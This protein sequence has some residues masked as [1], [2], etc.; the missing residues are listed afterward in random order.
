MRVLSNMCSP[1]CDLDT[2][3]GPVSYSTER[4]PGRLNAPSL[5]DHF[6]HSVLDVEEVSW[7]SL[8]KC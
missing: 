4:M 8:S 1:S 7:G 2:S 6:L 5:C 3:C